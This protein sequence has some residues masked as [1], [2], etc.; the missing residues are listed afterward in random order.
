MELRRCCVPG[1]AVRQQPAAHSRVRAGGGRLGAAA[2]GP[3]RGLGG[4]E[5]QTQRYL[6]FFNRPG[7]SLSGS[8][9]ENN[10]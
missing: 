2:G 6:S 10:E 9:F 8:R 3:H 5:P 1:G 7:V 4:Q